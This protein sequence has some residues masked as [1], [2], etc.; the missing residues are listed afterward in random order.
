MKLK[1]QGYDTLVRDSNSKAIISV[2]STDYQLYMKRVK[3]REQQGDEIRNA[4]K[5]INSLKTELEEIKNLLKEVIK[6]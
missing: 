1:V 2:A 3:M 6:K 4:V 5:E